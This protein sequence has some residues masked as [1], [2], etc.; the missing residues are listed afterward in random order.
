M[1]TEEKEYVRSL[2]HVE[3]IISIEPIPGADNIVKGTLL[4]W[5][6]CVKKDEFKVGDLAVYIECDSVCDITDPRFEFLKETKGR[7]KIRK[8]KKQISMGLALPLSILPSGNYKERQDCTN[9]LPISHY[10]PE[11]NLHKSNT[12][13]KPQNKVLKFL[14]KYSLCRKI[15][16]PFIKKPKGSWPQW[17]SRTDEERIQGHPGLLTRYQD[18]IFYYTEKLDGTSSTFFLKKMKF[19]LFNRM[20]FGVCSRNIWLKTP[21][22]SYYWKMARKYEIEKILRKDGRELIIQG[23]SIGE[24]V[25]KN[26][27]GIT[28][29]NLYV[30]N[31]IDSKT[32]RHFN[33]DEME[34]FCKKNNLNFVP[35]LGVIQLKETLTVKDLVEMSIGKSKLNEKTEREGLVFRYF[36][37]NGNKTSFKAISPKF[38]LEHE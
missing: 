31:I 26:K 14:L 29:L 15:I 28:G 33:L 9:L 10:D 32:N 37:S 36:D 2:A 5:E 35:V 20:I 30:F 16:L 6:L 22:E 38:L 11:S 25:Q 4:G 12:E 13:Y 27:Y 23:E 1:E 3:K 18:K 34:E 7:V 21:D 8:F 19:G 24:G 17:I